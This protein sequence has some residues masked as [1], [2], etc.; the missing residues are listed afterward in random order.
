LKCIAQYAFQVN[1]YPVILTLENHVGL[2]QQRI[3]V[4]IFK[5]ILGDKLY[6]PPDELPSKPLPS[7]NQLKN[8]I[9]LRGKTSAILAA[10]VSFN[11]NIIVITR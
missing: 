2:V 1:P 5:D 6:I 7:P 3:M 10:T 4:D 8:K 11:N 9:L